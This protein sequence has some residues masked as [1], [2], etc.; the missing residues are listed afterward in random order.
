[1]LESENQG[2]KSN[3]NPDKPGKGSLNTKKI[4]GWAACVLWLLSIILSFCIPT[5]SP[6]IFL[7]D[8]VLLLGFMPLILICPY[9]LVWIAF[10]VLTAF[11]GCFLLLLTHIPN[12]AL[13]ADTHAIKM[14]LAEFHPSW[15]W[16]IIGGVFAIAGILKLFYN[17]ALR[18]QA[19]RTAK[20]EL[21][22]SQKAD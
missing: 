3:E 13:P 20:E 11:I 17:L 16:M 8:T 7:P 9:S 19:G 15:S 18:L 14:H 21:P 22:Q 10:G 2:G 12:S 5:S 6:L 4:A 1:M